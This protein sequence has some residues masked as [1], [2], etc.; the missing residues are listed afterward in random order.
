MTHKR[1]LIHLFI[2]LL[3]FT[4]LLLSGCSDIQSFLPITP[5]RS[6]VL[7]VKDLDIGN[8][9]IETN[10]VE[11][12][13]KIELNKHILVLIQYIGTRQGNGV[14]TCELVL[15]TEKDKIFIGVPA[16]ACATR[17]MTPLKP[18]PSRWAA[19]GAAQPL[20]ILVIQQY[21]V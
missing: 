12:I 6:A 3:L 11:A 14:E 21:T 7:Y 16:M 9:T 15:E 5:E 1:T 17:L 19:H 20:K 8:F 4:T 10:S 18:Y 2:F 13:R